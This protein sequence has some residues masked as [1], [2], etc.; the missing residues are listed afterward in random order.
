M[1]LLP[2]TKRVIVVALI[3]VVLAC[4]SQAIAT[5][6]SRQRVH[7]RLENCRAALAAEIRRLAKVELGQQLS[8][9]QCGHNI[10][11]LSVRCET[12]HA[13]LQ[14][15]N[16][17]VGTVSESQVA[18]SGLPLMVW[19]RML[20]L[21]GAELVQQPPGSQLTSPSTGSSVRRR[22]HIMTSI[23]G[24]SWLLGKP[25]LSYWGGGVAITGKPWRVL[26][27]A[28]DVLA[29]ATNVGVEL[30]TIRSFALS[31]ALSLRTELDVRR[32]NIALAGGARLGIVRFVGVAV[33]EGVREDSF[34]ALWAGPLVRVSTTIRL[35]RGLVLALAVETGYVVL[36]VRATV[37]GA[38]RAAIEGAWGLF[39]SGLGWRW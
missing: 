32:L 33:S 2:G 27:W 14:L 20:S 31:A 38:K 37:D 24:A 1:M 34:W 7:L 29:A 16:P 23:V 17:H 11:E 28:A 22:G 30:G 25:M 6:H 21:A 18:E 12:G 4:G 35:W 13:T 26:G 36:P 3:G 15:R 39:S 19:A 9:E 10:A 5:E 8:D